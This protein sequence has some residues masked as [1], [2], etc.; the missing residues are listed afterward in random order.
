M[1][2][3]WGKNI[4]PFTGRAAYVLLLSATLNGHESGIME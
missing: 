1:W 2:L 4:G 3:K